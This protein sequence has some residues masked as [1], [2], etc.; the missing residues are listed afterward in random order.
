MG[1][2]WLGQIGPTA[3]SDT[4]VLSVCR[5]EPLPWLELHC[6]GGTEVV[7]LII[8]MFVDQGARE[9]DWDEFLR[10]AGDEPTTVEARIQL[11]RAPTVRTASILL[12]QAHGT[13]A[14][15]L[16][17]IR[18]ALRAGEGARAAALLDALLV[19]AA[20]GRHLVEPWR[21]VIAGA[22]NVGK[23][24][25]VN[26]LAGYERAIVSPVPGTTRDVVTTLLA[27]DGWPV[28]LADTAGWR[29]Q[30]ECLEQA[31]IALARDAAVHADLC[32]WVLDASTTPQFSAES[33]PVQYVVNKMDLP[34]A[35]ELAS[36]AGAIRVSAKTGAGLGELCERI[37]QTLVRQTPLP[38]EAVPFTRALVEQLGEARGE[39][40]RANWPAALA[41]LSMESSCSTSYHYA[42]S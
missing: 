6:H 32:L 37:S 11:A 18:A 16:E 20:L 40:A 25:L 21:I 41:G 12:D 24:S 8:E 36:L 5:L 39:C 29:T 26:A 19:H 17:S 13:F 33:V 34:A 35:W 30:A 27:I 31:G 3:E 2:I 42:Q 23:S 1:R 10:G 22:P 15:A 14:T 9:C 7:R 28:E 4:A 38:G